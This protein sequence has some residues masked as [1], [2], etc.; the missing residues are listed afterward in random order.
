[1]LSL[2]KIRNKNR[3]KENFT[4]LSF[5][6]NYVCVHTQLRTRQRVNIL[7][8]NQIWK[9]GKIFTEKKGP[10][11]IITFDL[12]NAVH[13][14]YLNKEG[15]KVHI[16]EGSN[17]TGKMYFCISWSFTTCLYL[18]FNFSIANCCILQKHWAS[19]HWN[20]NM[21]SDIVIVWIPF[22]QIKSIY[23]SV[24]DILKRKYSAK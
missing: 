5:Y 12:T 10:I 9:R 24:N 21:Y 13:L 23:R 18:T 20:W 2:I 11:S 7:C 22:L 14:H 3:L 16:I 8:R 19:I 1:M 4:F 6:N 15:H 17:Y